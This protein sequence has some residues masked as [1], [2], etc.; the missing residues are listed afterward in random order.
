MLG[1]LVDDFHCSCCF[2]GTNC[3]CLRCFLTQERE[4]VRKGMAGLSYLLDQNVDLPLFP[5]DLVILKT[6]MACLKCWSVLVDSRNL[7]SLGKDLHSAGSCHKIL[8]LI[9]SAVADGCTL[10][11]FLLFAG[12]QIFSLS[13][14]LVHLGKLSGF[15]LVTVLNCAH[16]LPYI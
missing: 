9:V 12:F 5:T 1:G 11:A 13:S 4:E 8:P 6:W 3:C 10:L 15:L 14:F 16:F 2:S 7:T